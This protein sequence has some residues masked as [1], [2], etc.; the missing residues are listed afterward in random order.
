[1]ETD[2]DIEDA[3]QLLDEVGRFARGRIAALASRPEWPMSSAQLVQLT[4]EAAELGILSS[5]MS[6]GGFGLWEHVDDEPSMAF[7]TGALK[8]IAQANPGV[9]LAWHRM[10]LARLVAS[11]LGLQLDDVALPGLVLVPTGHYGLARNSLARWLQAVELQDDDHR[12]LADW[13]DRQ[14]HATVVC[15][16]RD[17][18]QLLWPRWRDGRIVWQLIDRAALIVTV[19]AAQHGLDELAGFAVTQSTSP[20]RIIETDLATSRLLYA[21]VLKLDMLGLLA[22]GAG[23]LERG[24]SLARDYASIRRQGG[25]LIAAHPAVQHMLSDIEITLGQVD[26]ALAACAKPVDALDAGVVAAARASLSPA[27]CHAANQVIQ[28]HGGIGYMRDA[29]P[30]KLVRDMNMLKMMTG[31][32]RDIHAFVAG[33]TGVSA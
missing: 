12:M 27:L 23:A 25:Q 11:L 22:I 29:G 30:E 28:V 31:G 5:S 26:M 3:R 6:Q 8:Q 21:R 2:M 15:A 20:A 7:N 14:A 13:L 19:G 1:M 17:W 10:A 32:V 9:A 4:Q 18:T 16:P 24:R 33:W